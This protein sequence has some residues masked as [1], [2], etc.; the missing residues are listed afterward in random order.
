VLQGEH[1]ER[2]EAMN[3]IDDR[4]VSVAATREAQRRRPGLPAL[5]LPASL[6]A[7]R[8]LAGRALSRRSRDLEGTDVGAES[9]PSARIA[10]SPLFLSFVA[11]VLVPTA[12]AIVYLFF[13][14]ADQYVA[15]ARFAVR[16]AEDISFEQKPRGNNNLLAA[17]L[18]SSAASFAQQD[19]EIVASYIRSRAIID[20]LEKIVD[21]RAIFS[22]PE[23]DFW[24]RLPDN[25]SAEVLRDY[26]LQ[27]VTAYLEHISGIV[28]VKVRAFRRDDALALANAIVAVSER[29][30]NSISLRARADAM[31]RAEEEV[32]RADGL[33]RL[34]L[35]DLAHFRDAE[36]IIDPV[37]AADLTG[38]VLLQLMQDK[39]KVD[40]ELFI[41]QR[42][43]S[44][45]APGI[46]SLRARLE[47]VEGQIE[48][49]RAELAGAD[50]QARNL[51][52]VLAKFEELEVKRQFAESVYAFARD[53][54]D[55]ARI[56]AERQTIY[57]TVFVPPALPQEVAFP[58][59]FTYS[60][61]IAITLIIAWATG[62]MICASILDHRI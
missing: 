57:V 21:V 37:K 34:A 19:A 32:R 20:D 14:A 10:T 15:E 24:E 11:C 16:A 18:P 58:L 28:Y 43:S 12:A 60:A 5:R 59:R 1:S 4:E 27:K 23:A 36:G 13:L 6:E 38:K 48:R 52:G 22:R 2:I 45:D 33:M 39:I 9:R 26:W 56:T 41:L 54:L 62:A 47:S 51:A 3:D 7:L 8:A 44:A 30:V 17:A 40:T 61:L 50:P 55:R 31:R 25:A 35:A 42:V 53:G 49:T 29:L 46:A